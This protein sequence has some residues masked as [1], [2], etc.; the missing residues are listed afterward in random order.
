MRGDERKPSGDRILT[1]PLP[2]IPERLKQH[3]GS[4]DLIGEIVLQ[5]DPNGVIGGDSSELDQ[6]LHEEIIQSEGEK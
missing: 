5:L 4:P 1:T 6:E 2:A 3:R